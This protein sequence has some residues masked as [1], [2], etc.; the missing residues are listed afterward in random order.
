[1]GKVMFSLR[2]SVHTWVAGGGG[3]TLYPSYST[4]TGPMSFLEGTPVTGP[5]PLRWWGGGGY[6]SPRWSGVPPPPPPART[7]T[8]HQSEYLLRGGWYASSVH[9]GVLSCF[10][11]KILPSL[12]YIQMGLH[13][14]QCCSPKPL[15]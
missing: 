2:L 5:K 15:R 3:F 12:L 9:A 8:E 6:P 1:M 4:S 13:L 7:G 14:F 10:M 11:L